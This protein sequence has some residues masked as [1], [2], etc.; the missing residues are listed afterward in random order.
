MGHLPQLGVPSG[1]MSAPGIR[2]LGWREAER[3]NLTASPPGWPLGFVIREAVV[4]CYQLFPLTYLVTLRQES[5]QNIFL[6]PSHVGLGHMTSFGQQDV[7]RSDGA[8]VPSQSLKGCRMFPP[9][10]FTTRGACLK[11]QLALGDEE[12]RG[13][14][15][16]LSLEPGTVEPS[17]ASQPTDS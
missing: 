5:G 12:T 15:L 7:S 8:L 6:H 10:P 9:L 14:D 17:K 1:A 13:A 2:T 4:D 3:G 11:Q 16:S